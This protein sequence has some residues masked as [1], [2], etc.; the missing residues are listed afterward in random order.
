M[1]LCKEII[2]D[3]NFGFA[4]HATILLDFFFTCFYSH[5]PLPSPAVYW[6]NM[7]EKASSYREVQI[8]HKYNC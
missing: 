3:M 4:V 1:L 5:F 2:I 8:L 7:K 6:W